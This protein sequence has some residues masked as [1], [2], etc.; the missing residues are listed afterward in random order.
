MR[1]LLAG[2]MSLVART[3]WMPAGPGQVSRVKRRYMV[4]RLRDAGYTYSQIG[5]VFGLSAEA[6]REVVLSRERWVVRYINET[7]DCRRLN[8]CHDEHGQW[9]RTD[10]LCARCGGPL[11][12]NSRTAFCTRTP[13]CKAAYMREYYMQRD[14]LRELAR[15]ER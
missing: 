4:I 3:L 15:R 7:C 2:A 12:Q 5:G 13:E 6:A 10:R 14:R 9:E 1:L 11:K 8:C